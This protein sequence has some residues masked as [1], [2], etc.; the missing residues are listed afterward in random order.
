[1]NVD[2]CNGAVGVDYCPSGKFLHVARVFDQRDKKLARM[3]GND[4][5]CLKILSRS[6]ARVRMR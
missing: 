6:R 4:L 5:K 2:K 3:V 1:M